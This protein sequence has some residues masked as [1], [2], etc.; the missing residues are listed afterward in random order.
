MHVEISIYKSTK[1]RVALLIDG[2]RVSDKLAHGLWQSA[3][4]LVPRGR[5]SRQPPKLSHPNAFI[6]N[7][8]RKVALSLYA[9]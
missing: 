7:F 1:S 6:R 9:G 2:R 5:S 8:M 4:F 3:F